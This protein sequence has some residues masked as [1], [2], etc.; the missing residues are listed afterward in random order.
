MSV[1]SRLAQWLWLPLVLVFLV[2]VV[3]VVGSKEP[4]GGASEEVGPLLSGRAAL[5]S[6]IEASRGRPVLVNLWATW[7]TPCVGELPH[8]AEVRDSLYPAAEVVAVSVGDPDPEPVVQLHSQAGLSLPVVWLDRGE[9]EDLLTQWDVP[10]VLPVTIAFGAD[11]A[12]TARVAGARGRDDFLAMASGL[13]P[14]EDSSADGGHAGLHV[15]VVGPAGDPVTGRL[16]L[17]AERLAG[18]DAVDFYD[19]GVPEDSAAIDSLMLP[20]MD[21]PYAQPCVGLACGRPVSSPEMLEEAAAAL[22]GR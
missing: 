2:P 10:D 9:S 17:E 11:G 8:L 20:R 19:P 3:L 18:G 6:V 12:E 4:A 7:C 15:N 22:M 14:E 13:V 1:A 16:L 21:R 5:D